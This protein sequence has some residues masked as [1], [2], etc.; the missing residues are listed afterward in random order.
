MKSLVRILSATLI[1]AGSALAVTATTT[2][3]SAYC[4]YS[5]CYSSQYHYNQYHKKSYRRYNGY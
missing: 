4:N 2:P 3:A 1:A 5:G